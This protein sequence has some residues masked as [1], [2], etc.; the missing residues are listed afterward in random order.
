MFENPSMERYRNTQLYNNYN[1]IMLMF[2]TKIKITQDIL[3]S[4][5]CF[6]LASIEKLN[7]NVNQP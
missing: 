2:L 5:H 6:L 7:E 4:K 1:F 3:Q